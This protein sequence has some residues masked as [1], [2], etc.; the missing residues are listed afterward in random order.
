VVIS[1]RGKVLSQLSL[2]H[3]HACCPV[4]PVSL[5]LALSLILVHALVLRPLRHRREV[6]STMFGGRSA[7]GIAVLL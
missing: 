2:S 6:Q 5:A 1:K 3:V 7:C 4:L